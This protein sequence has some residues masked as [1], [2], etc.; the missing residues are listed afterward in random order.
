[1]LTTIAI[2]IIADRA[3]EYRKSRQASFT[4]VRQKEYAMV[5]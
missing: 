3:G 4:A 2:A 5:A 1:M